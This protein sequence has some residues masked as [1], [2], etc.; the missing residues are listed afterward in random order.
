MPPPGFEAFLNAICANPADDLVR[1]VYAD[2]LDE[3]GDPARAEY[4]RLQIADETAARPRFQRRISE[5]NR[6]HGAAWRAELPVLTGIDWGAFRRG[7][8]AHINVRA[9]GANSAVL[10]SAFAAAPVDTITLSP[11]RPG[12]F[13]EILRTDQF[14][15]IRSIRLPSGYLDDAVVCQLAAD[16]RSA[17][18][19]SLQL[20]GNL[21]GFVAGSRVRIPQITDR[22][23]V[24]LARSPHLGNLRRLDLRNVDITRAGH[25]ALRDRFGLGFT[26]HI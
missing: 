23:A 16:P 15:Q 17:G 3:H 9:S 11:G 26:C 6:E 25:D 19:V 12:L 1:L 4:I 20:T 10:A 22:S 8:L 21:W 13:R 7:F 2:W 24:A 18:L 14:P 5:L